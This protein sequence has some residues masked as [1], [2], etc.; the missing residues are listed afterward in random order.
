MFNN[1]SNNNFND[2]SSLLILGILHEAIMDFS[3]ETDL[4]EFWKLVCIMP[5]GLFRLKKCVLFLSETHYGDSSDV[6]TINGKLVSVMK[7]AKFCK[8]TIFLLPVR[9]I[10]LKM[11]YK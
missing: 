7:K 8:M 3:R 5:N 11:F 9:M 10:L 1:V 6:L 4:N 2:N